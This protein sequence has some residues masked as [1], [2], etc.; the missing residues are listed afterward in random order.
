MEGRQDL[1]SRRQPLQVCAG[2]QFIV[3]LDTS[4]HQRI[5]GVEL[6]ERLARRFVEE[7]VTAE[8]GKVLLLPDAYGAFCSMLKERALDPLKRSDF[9][10]MVVPMIK[11]AYNVCLRNDLVV[12]DR[13]GVRGW[14]N[15]ALNQTV[16][17]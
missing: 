5:R 7:L 15:V 3:L 11:D 14:K 12:D 6:H 2:G 1:Q 9:K 10:A 13:Q 8:P 17:A 16:P 4:P